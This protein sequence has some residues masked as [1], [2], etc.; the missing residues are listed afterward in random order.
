[1][2]NHTR[3]NTA[4]TFLRFAGLPHTLSSCFLLLGE[5]KD[6]TQCLQM[7]EIAPIYWKKK[8]GWITL[9]DRGSGKIKMTGWATQNPARTE[10]E[11]TG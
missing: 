1:M 2:V 6:P 5:K 8:K 10:G 9:E 3:I 11:Q 4:T 7:G